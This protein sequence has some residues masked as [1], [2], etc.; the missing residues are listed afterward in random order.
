[1]AFHDVL[2]PTGISLGAQ[3]GPERRTD[4]VAL[5]SG[6]EQRNARWADSRRSYNAGY[7]VRSLDD[8]HEVLAF[9]EERRGRLHGFRWRDPLD[10]RSGPPGAAPSPLDQV[11]G[12]G[13]GETLLF[14]LVKRY[15]SQFQPWDR[16]IAKPVAGSIKVAVNGIEQAVGADYQADVTSGEVVF[17]SASIPP[18]GSIVTAGFDFDVP[19]RF[20]TDRLE[21][22]LQSFRAGAIPNIP[23]IEV[24]L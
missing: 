1:M 21:V 5:G 20:D 4:I 6:H 17:L 15:G 19:V 18:P 14:R 8:L 2:F 13:D 23:I 16:T 22:S 9:F 24:R 12:T 3:G 7:G 10:W 11:I